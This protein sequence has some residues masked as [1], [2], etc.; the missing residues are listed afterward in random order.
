MMLPLIRCLQDSQQLIR[1]PSAP[2]GAAARVNIVLNEYRQA[3]Q[4]WALAHDVFQPGRRVMHNA[5]SASMHPPPR[6]LPPEHRPA[7]VRL[8]Q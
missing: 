6:C 1:A 8:P 4:S 7:T 2:G 5:L 3:Q